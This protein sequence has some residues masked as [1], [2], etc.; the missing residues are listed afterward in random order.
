MELYDIAE[1][2]NLKQWILGVAFEAAT[3][4]KADYLAQILTSPASAALGV[5]AIGKVAVGDD[6]VSADTIAAAVNKGGDEL[7]LQM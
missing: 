5:A 1:R 3:A 7:A 6:T 4:A 2:T